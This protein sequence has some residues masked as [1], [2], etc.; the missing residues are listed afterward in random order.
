MCIYICIHIHTYTY[1]YI[2]LHTHTYIY[3][4]IHTYLH[5]YIHT[6][7]HTNIQTYIYMDMILGDVIWKMIPH[8]VLKA[9]LDEVRVPWLSRDLAAAKRSPAPR[10]G[11]VGKGSRC[12]P[13]DPTTFS[14]TKYFY[15][16][17]CIC[18]LVH[19]IHDISYTIL[20]QCLICV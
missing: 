15:T 5:T 14:R 19:D 10:N 1:I 4:H 11:S 3:I 7:K 16:Y 9:G 20:F 18:I 17:R 12:E 2:H 8:A 13:W 6:Y